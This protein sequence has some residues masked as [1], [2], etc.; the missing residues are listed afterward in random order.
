MLALVWSSRARGETYDDR[1][2]VAH[3]RRRLLRT[4][5]PV[6]DNAGY[7]KQP[8]LAFLKIHTHS[9]SLSLCHP[10]PTP[11]LTPIGRS[12]ALVD[13]PT[14]RVVEN[15]RI[16]FLAARESCSQ[17][18]LWL[19]HCSGLFFPTLRE[20]GRGIRVE[21]RAS[22]KASKHTSKWGTWE[23]LT[24]GAAARRLQA[25]VEAIVV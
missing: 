8:G 16:G 4:E 3:E 20:K 11:P 24:A 6:C 7:D 21:S 13:L 9:F 19:A 18:D 2:L 22:L 12:S 5:W 14:G 1:V 15:A 10:S 17:K 23:L 25:I